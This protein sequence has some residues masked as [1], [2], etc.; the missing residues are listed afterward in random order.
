MSDIDAHWEGNYDGL[1]EYWDDTSAETTAF[2]LKLLMK[3]DRASGL[4]PKAAVWLAGHRDGDYWYS[5]KQTA[6]VIQG[7]TDYVAL[8]GELANSS[9]VEVL[10]NGASVGS[11][12]FGPGDGFAQPWQ[13]KFPPAQASGGGQVTVRKSGNGITYGRLRAP[14]TRQTSGLS[15]KASWRSTSRATITC[16][17]SGRTSRPI[18]LR[19]TWRR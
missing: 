18:R 6:M 12:H 5:T 14:G 11:R 16:C 9:D 1:L 7:L 2:A 15:S 13:I 17:R 19:T 3:Q 10:V 4:L 8:S